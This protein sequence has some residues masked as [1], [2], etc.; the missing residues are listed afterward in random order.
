M[1]VGT[2]KFISKKVS[3]IRWLPQTDTSRLES[4]TLVNTSLLLVLHVVLG[5]LIDQ[6]PP[7]WLLLHR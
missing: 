5:P 2:G 6:T 7:H 4:S 3:K 1:T